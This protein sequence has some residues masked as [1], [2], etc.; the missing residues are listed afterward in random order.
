MKFI[1]TNLGVELLTPEFGSV[2]PNSGND[3]AHRM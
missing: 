3:T 2:A 1:D